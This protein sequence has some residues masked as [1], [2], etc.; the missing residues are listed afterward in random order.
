MNLRNLAD[1]DRLVKLIRDAHA[2]VLMFVSNEDV[3][4]EI[5]RNDLIVVDAANGKLVGEASPEE[6][7]KHRSDLK[8]NAVTGEPELIYLDKGGV[9]M[10]KHEKGKRDEFR[11]ATGK[12]ERLEH[13]CVIYFWKYTGSHCVCTWSG[14]KHRLRCA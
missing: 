11:V 7:L 13:S 12:S 10:V 2:D 3:G 4:S 1:R 5:K 8:V 14:G 6:H 9:P